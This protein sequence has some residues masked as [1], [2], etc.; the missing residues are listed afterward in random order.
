MQEASAVKIQANFFKI[1]EITGGFHQNKGE[2]HQQF[3]PNTVTT[4]CSLNKDFPVQH[5]EPLV[6]DSMNFYSE[7]RYYE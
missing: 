5:C 4:P 7:C 3:N 1:Q 2:F 6:V